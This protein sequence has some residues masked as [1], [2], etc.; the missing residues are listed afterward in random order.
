MKNIHFILI[1]F[2]GFIVPTVLFS[3]INEAIEPEV[4]GLKVIDLLEG[5]T[6]NAWKVPSNHWSFDKGV[7]IGDTGHEKLDTPEWIYSK[8]QFGDFEFTCEVKLAGDTFRN[9]GV[10]FRVTTFHFTEKKRNKSYEAP[11]GYEFDVSIP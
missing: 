1:L 6:L 5:G 3:Q 7:I 10:Y 2:L 8:Q 4:N 11:S 9:T